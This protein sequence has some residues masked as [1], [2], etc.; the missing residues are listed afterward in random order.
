MTP[1][2][3][4]CLSAW[5]RACVR[6]ADA[7]P[8]ET[9]G[10]KCHMSL[11][12]WRCSQRWRR[13]TQHFGHHGSHECRGLPLRAAPARSTSSWDSLIDDLIRLP[14]PHSS[15]KSEELLIPS[16]ASCVLPRLLLLHWLP[17]RALWGESVHF[18]EYCCFPVV[19]Y[20]WSL[21]VVLVCSAWVLW[22]P[23][24]VQRRAP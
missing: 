14:S 1:L 7:S 17:S 4:C 3:R 10:P 16:S 18:V 23:H 5:V 6:A 24:T 22:L 2:W 20:L 19:C 11:I 8:R 15:W 12:D 13:A 21:C 9:G